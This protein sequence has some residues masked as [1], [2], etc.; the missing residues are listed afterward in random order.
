LNNSRIVTRT[1]LFFGK[2]KY[3]A[4]ICNPNF[5]LIRYSK[6]A[7]QLQDTI[8]FRQQS[9]VFFYH[10]KMTNDIDTDLLIKFIDWRNNQP[11]DITIRVDYDMISVYSNDLFQLQTIEHVDTNVDYSEVKVD[12]DPGILERNNPKHKY[13]TY[14]RCRSLQNADLHT[15]M[16]K[17]LQSYEKSVY[18]CG[19]LR[20]WAFEIKDGQNWRKHYLEASFFVDYDIESI[21][22]ILGLTF[23]SYLG[24]TYKVEQR[25]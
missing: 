11:K 2:Y 7:K 12:G 17:F 23:D 14:F 25:D 22:T 20:R 18:P 4:V 6:T 13:R 5:H 19:A 10:G 16:Q 8:A 3:R 24:K 1:K 21:Q 15:E 9:S